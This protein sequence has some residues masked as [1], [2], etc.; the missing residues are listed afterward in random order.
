MSR[1]LLSPSRA[2]AARLER[3]AGLPIRPNELANYRFPATLGQNELAYAGRW[4][5]GNERAVPSAG[6]RLRLHFFAKKV[7]LVLGGHGSARVLVN[8]KPLRT[9]RVTSDRLYT[10]VDSPKELKAI[11]E[12][13]F[14]SGVSAYAFTFG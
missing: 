8:G 6:A 4:T 14:S 9:V 10:L 1:E 3:Y 12:L 2:G 11:L 7:F 13:R 5:I